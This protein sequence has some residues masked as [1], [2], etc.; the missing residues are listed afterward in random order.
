GYG[1]S[2][3]T[4]CHPAQL[5]VAPPVAGDGG[6]RTRTGPQQKAEG[7][8][9]DAGASPAG[10]AG[11]PELPATGVADTTRPAAATGRQSGRAGSVARPCVRSS[12]LKPPPGS[13]AGS[14]L[15]A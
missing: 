4:G 3:P 7:S 6:S 8:A 2:P 13:S 10:P 5:A 14:R 12:F 15:G 1:R 11:R 9:T